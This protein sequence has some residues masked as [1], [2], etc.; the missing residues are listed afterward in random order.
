MSRT[1]SDS[2]T[3]R[4]HDCGWVVDAILACDGEDFQAL[5]SEVLSQGRGLRF[6]ATGGSMHPFI[7]NGDLLLVEPTAGSAVG[8]GEVVLYRTENGGIT[9]HRVVGKRRDGGRE[10]LTTKGDAVRGAALAVPCGEVLGR[11]IT[12]ERQGTEIRLDGG[13]ARAVGLVY[14]LSYLVAQQICA[15]LG[16][17]ANVLRKMATIV[18]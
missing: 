4:Q 11:V 2:N 17:M 8:L 16:K 5:A 9:A 1:P 10:F 6:R 7:R 12:I 15:A 3:G 13:G 18:G 14:V